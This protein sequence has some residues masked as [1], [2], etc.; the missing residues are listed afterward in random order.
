MSNPTPVPSTHAM[1]RAYAIAP[2][3]TPITFIAIVSLVGVT[4][5]A[6]AIAMGF[7]ACYLVAGFIGMPIAFSLRRLNSLNVCTIHGA[8]L[9]WGILWSLFCT[10]SAIYVVAA[11]DGSIQSL[12]MTVGWF[13][14]VMVPP[15][16]LAGT[17]FWLLVKNPKW[18]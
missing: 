1:W 8:A 6:N 9:I 11:T 13:I 14:A 17:A 18:I 4:L 12:P 15:V 5:P 16:V 2:S 10:V 3:V 7:F